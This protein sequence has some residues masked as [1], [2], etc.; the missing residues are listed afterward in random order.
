M[1]LDLVHRWLDP[2]NSDE[3]LEVV[4]GE[5]GYSNILDL[6]PSKHSADKRCQEHAT[7]ALGKER[8]NLAGGE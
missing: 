1:E 3:F 2:G 7:R 5:V 6:I 4:D 8:S